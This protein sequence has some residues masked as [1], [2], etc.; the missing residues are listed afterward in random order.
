MSPARA[1]TLLPDHL[2]ICRL[3]PD[4]P[5]PAW[6]FHESARLWCL[7]RTPDELSVTCPEDDVP[8]SI[9]R[10]ERGW[11]AFRLEGPI[12]FGEVGVVAG[13]T[14]PLAAAGVPVFVLSTYDTD[15]VLVK[16]ADLE[17]ARGAL[18]AKFTLRG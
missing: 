16:V 5:L 13:V 4:A 14:A 3:D 12:P 8:P 17:R 10:V 6:V 1:L 7:M 9:T 2:A 15:Y 18:A 11:R